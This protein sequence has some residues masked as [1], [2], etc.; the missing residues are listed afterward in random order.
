M[1]N[2]EILRHIAETDSIGDLFEIVRSAAERA[3]YIGHSDG[4]MVGKRN[5]SE[6]ATS[7][8]NISTE[9]KPAWGTYLFD[10]KE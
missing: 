10:E 5:A 9:E 6:A 2:T 4:Q 7:G 1:I 3:Y 8:E